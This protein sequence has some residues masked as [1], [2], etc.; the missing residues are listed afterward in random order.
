MS[1]PNTFDRSDAE[2]ILMGMAEN[3]DGYEVAWD[4]VRNNW[5]TLKIM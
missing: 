4:F 2:I 1:D 3:S 5:E